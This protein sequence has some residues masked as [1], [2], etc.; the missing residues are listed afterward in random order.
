MKLAVIGGGGFRT[1]LLVAGLIARRERLP[2]DWVVLHDLDATALEVVAALADVMLARSGRLFR[3]RTTTDLDEAL[4]SPAFLI[5]SIRVGGL[6]GRI[7]DEQVPLAHGVIGQETTGPGGWAM[8]LRTIPVLRDIAARLRRSAP[9]AWIINFTNPAGLITQALVSSGEPRVIG[10]CDSPPAL[11]DRIAAALGLPA[12]AMRLDYLGLNHLG[13]VRAVWVDG[14]DR[15]PD[16]LARDEVVRS[17]YGR[18][19]F[20]PD[21]VRRL[22]LLPNEYL[23]YYYHH[24][25]AL[26]RLRRAPQ[27]RGQ[28]VA[29]MAARLRGAVLDALARGEDPWSVYEQ[30]VFARR[31]SYMAT[32]T[33]R[34]RD[35]A[36]MGGHV[37]G[38]YARVAL[39]VIEAMLHSDQREVIVNTVNR[40]AIDDFAE[41]DVVE[42]P[43]RLGRDGPHPRPMGSMPGQVRDLAVR[44]KAYERQ[45]VAAALT[46]SW[47]TAV[48]ALRAHPL[49]PSPAVADAV[50]EDLRYRHAPR[51]DYLH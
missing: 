4:D 47:Q 20:E 27:T 39:G 32:E 3:V 22:G 5:T 44:V 48:E 36:M 21:E 6:E 45:T 1:P 25:E 49:L 24:D 17:V 8:A 29:Q 38:G 34:A 11:A 40:G 26:R 30:A 37:E 42:V 10:I 28:A 18:P 43:C 14:T 35:L 13:W 2:V 31:S 46:G 33:G 16:I 50:A 15:L 7:I 41:D 19:L 12:S 9:D 51:L 23:H